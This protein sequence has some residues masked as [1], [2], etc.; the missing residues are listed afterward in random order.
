MPGTRANHCVKLTSAKARPLL[1]NL[2]SKLSRT[3]TRQFKT[4]R[5]FLIQCFLELHFAVR[6]LDGALVGPGSTPPLLANDRRAGT[7]LLRTKLRWIAADQS[8]VK[9]AHS[10]PASSRRTPKDSFPS[11]LPALAAVKV[12]PVLAAPDAASASR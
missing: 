8:A 3:K 2:E 12:A 6:R 7:R 10:K 11:G 1:N 5:R 9:P 4:H